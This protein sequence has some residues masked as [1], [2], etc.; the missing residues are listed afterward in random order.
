M[1]E[2]ENRG[3]QQPKPKPT[4]LSAPISTGP[5]SS[6]S[7]Q[8]PC[9]PGRPK[10][11]SRIHPFRTSRGLVCTRRSHRLDGGMTVSAND[12]QDRIQGHWVALT[13]HGKG[14]NVPA[15]LTVL[16]L[17]DRS[18]RSAK[19][20]FK[21]Q[22]EDVRAGHGHSGSVRATLTVSTLETKGI[23]SAKASVWP[24]LSSRSSKLRTPWQCP[25]RP[26]R[27]KLLKIQA[28]V[29]Q[30]SAAGVYMKTFEQAMDTVAVSVPP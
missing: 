7:M 17:Q 13:N 1:Q 20:G 26:G 21:R 19:V 30:K 11:R 5:R 9:C 15:T 2:D 28:S 22:Q 8:C 12:L 23:R 16:T 25:C 18:I 6:K 27:P 24:V 14:G 10:P 29:P 3:R 4:E